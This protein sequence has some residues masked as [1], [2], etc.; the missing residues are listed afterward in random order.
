MKQVLFSDNFMS[1]KLGAWPFETL[2]GAMGEYH[3][4]PKEWYGGQWYD[5]TPQPGSGN[6]MFWMI[7]DTDD[8]KCIEYSGNRSHEDEFWQMLLATGELDW[9]DY[10]ISGR[11]RTWFKNNVAGIAFRYLTSNQYYLLALSGGKLR[12]IL[13][14]ATSISDIAS[15]DVDYDCDHFYTLSATCVGN[16]ITCYLD[17]KEMI[18]VEDST[19]SKGKIGIATLGPAQFTDI[20]VEMN[21]DIYAEITKIRAE[22]QIKL[23][24]ERAKYPQ[25]HL[26]KVINCKDFGAGRNIR[27]GHL[28]GGSEWH[29]VIAQNQ[30]RIHRDSNARINCLTAIDLEGNVL[31]Q[32]GEPIPVD[33][34]FI[35]CDLP[36]QVYDIDND[37]KDE[38]IYARDFKLIIADGETGKTKKWMYTPRLSE[39]DSPP[40]FDRLN[41]DSIRICNFTGKERPSDLLIKD[42]YKTLWAYDCDFNLLW[43]YT[44]PLNPGHYPYAYDFNG[45]GKDELYVGYDML[46]SNG[47]RLWSLDVHTDHTD[48]IIVGKL[49]PEGEE[50]IAIVSG[51][52]GFIIADFDGN[53]IRRHNL[54]HAQRISVGNYRQDLPGLQICTT[55]YH[56]NQ[57][58]I[59]L[60]DCKG[61]NLWN[62]EPGSNGSI[63]TPVNWTGDGRDLILLNGNRKFG[64]MMDGHGRQVVVFPDDG[65]AELCAEAIDL[66]GDCRDEIV[67]WDHERIYIY[68]QDN[69]LKGEVDCPRKY[70]HYNCSN[71]RGEYSFRDGI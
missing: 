49:D 22:K 37:G 3:Y 55:T 7:A 2:L 9:T 53:I 4:R 25:P 58:I 65:H 67:L 10:S 8:G 27:F 59:S 19:Y 48:E 29:I 23:A 63:I 66:A 31:W 38:V 1:Y 71:Y 50:V 52:E 11:V 28:K 70:P 46:D 36:F 61:E 5:P 45:D 12:L 24:Q 47:K 44:A 64:G 51:Y 54:G 30:K 20:L 34:A 18:S 43:K 60:F 16:Q 14:E 41:V 68:T 17:G 6:M 57:G 42:R 56:Q 21:S 33:G 40:P 13:H 35:T 62:W 32:I 15:V 69:V 39:G 26:W